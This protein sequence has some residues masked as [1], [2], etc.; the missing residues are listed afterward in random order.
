MKSFLKDVNASVVVFLVA[1]PLCLGIALA[2][3]APLVSG[4][5]SGI[6]GGIVVAILG[7][8]QI[9]VSGP[10]AGLTVVVASAI[11][12]LGSF[13]MFCKALFVAGVLQ[14][15]LAGFGF[16]KLGRFIPLAVTKALLSAIGILICYKELPY[17]FGTDPKMFYSLDVIQNIRGEIIWLSIFSLGSIFLWEILREKLT[18]FRHVPSQLIGVVVAG[19][20]CIFAQEILHIQFKATDFVQLPAFHLT[21]WKMFSAEGFLSKDVW[22][23][24][25]TLSLIASIETLLC[26][27]AGLLLDPEKRPIYR[28]KELFSQGVGNTLCGVL[29]GLPVT[30]VIVRTAANIDAGA[31]TYKSAVLHGLWILIFMLFF[32]SMAQ[33]IPLAALAI[34][35]IL[36]GYKLFSPTVYKLMKQKGAI[37]FWTYLTTIC[38]IL[39]TDILIGVTL[40]S[41]FYYFMQRFSKGEN[42]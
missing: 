14:I 30:A 33:K 7:G 10:A 24:A 15:F 37:H 42:L 16:D 8:S 20:F 25:M 17:I 36:V 2:S 18:W 9:A 38:I 11:Q 35:L 40:G 4:L 6:I 28:R 1:L 31:K 26:L 12:T 19:F 29:G 13:N 21:E 5:V 27:E 22:I 39:F 23:V 34:V 32:N 41:A 3:E